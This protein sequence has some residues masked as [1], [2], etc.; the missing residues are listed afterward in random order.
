MG[1]VNIWDAIDF[2][3]DPEETAYDLLRTQSEVLEART[4]SHLSMQVAFVD[5]YLDVEP[6]QA[7]FAYPV[8]IVANHLGRYRKKIFTVVQRKGK[9][10]FPV[11]IHSHLDDHHYPDISKDQFLKTIYKILGHPEVSASIKSLYDMSIEKTQNR[12]S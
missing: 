3:V 12:A 9:A 10:A 11:D 5:T 1:N 2:S 4:E 6:P 8:F 7:V